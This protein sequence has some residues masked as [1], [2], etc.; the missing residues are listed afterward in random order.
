MKYLKERDWPIRTDHISDGNPPEVVRSKGALQ[1]LE[2]YNGNMPGPKRPS[3]ANVV[4][5]LNRHQCPAPFHTVRARFM[6]SIASPL[7][8]RTPVHTIQELWGGELPPF[9]GMEDL[10]HLFQILIDGLWNRLIVHQTESN[11]FKLT[12]LQ[13][14]QTREG[15]HHYALVRKQEIEGFMD[16]LFGPHEE[17]DLPESA[18]EAVEVLGEIRAMFAGAITLLEDAG[19]PAAPDDLKGLS[20]NL[21]GLATILEK[22]MNTVVLSCTRA[23]SQAL[24]EMQQAKPTVH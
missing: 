13:V 10:N 23:R 9:N 8:G 7:P 4:A 6:G 17:I 21:H 1:A 12:R 19:M 22:E 3:S 11:P 5:A 20:G 14:S 15:I 24:A 18:R 16:G 2:T